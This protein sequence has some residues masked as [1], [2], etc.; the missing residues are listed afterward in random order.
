MYEV[1]RAKPR[2]RCSN[3]SPSRLC[4]A[5]GVAFE[6]LLRPRCSMLLRAVANDRLGFVSELSSPSAPPCLRY[7]YCRWG[8]P[9][10]DY[11]S[12]SFSNISRLS[13]LLMRSRNLLASLTLSNGTEGP[14]LS[15]TQLEVSLWGPA[16]RRQEPVSNNRWARRQSPRFC[17][18][19]QPRDG[20][21]FEGLA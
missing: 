2:G 17:E 21:I 4:C 6:R 11:P 14:K 1:T 10:T 16:R 3:G 9:V 8:P 13:R 12:N 19:Y 7:Y 18:P 15:C 5:L 20:W